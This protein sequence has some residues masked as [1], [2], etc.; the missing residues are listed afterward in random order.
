[1]FH[2]KIISP[3]TEYFPSDLILLLNDSCRAFQDENSHSV[4]LLH[5]KEEEENFV[6]MNKCLRQVFPSFVL[7]IQR[8]AR[9][10]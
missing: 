9:K 3:S 8:A 7:Q 2:N 6:A 4:C 1:M 5:S 10:E